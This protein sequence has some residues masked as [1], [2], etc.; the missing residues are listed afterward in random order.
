M[1]IICPGYYPVPVGIEAKEVIPLIEKYIKL[2][3]EIFIG[4][5]DRLKQMQR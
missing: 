2:N 1:R 4:F 3:G 5:L